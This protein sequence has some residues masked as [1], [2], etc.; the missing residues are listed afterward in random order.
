MH[1]QA[2]M[3]QRQTDQTGWK[4]KHTKTRPPISSSPGCPAPTTYKC[5]PEGQ[6]G[7]IHRGISGWEPTFKPIYADD[8]NAHSLG[9]LDREVDVRAGTGGEGNLISMLAFACL[10]VVPGRSNVD[11]ILQST[12]PERPCAPMGDAYMQG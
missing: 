3:C 6:L 2:T 4:T 9:S 12:H 8:I 11:L 5:V 7:S 10:I 1:G